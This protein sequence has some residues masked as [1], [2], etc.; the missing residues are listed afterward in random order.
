[1]RWFSILKQGRF[2]YMEFQRH[3]RLERINRDF[4]LQRAYD[5]YTIKDRVWNQ[6]IDRNTPKQNYEGHTFDGEGVNMPSIP[7][8]EHYLG[9]YLTQDDFTLHSRNFLPSKL[10]RYD[11]NHQEV[12]LDR[13][14]GEDG[15]REIM[16]RYLEEVDIMPEEE[17]K[18]VMTHRFSD[19]REINIISPIYGGSNIGNE[20]FRSKGVTGEI[21]RFLEE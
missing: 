18:E 16:R 11:R 10:E 20:N 15:Q 1:M 4:P 14:G 19:G 8:L 7:L 13:L 9:R 2:H 5:S 6:A 21:N 12:L 3:E 17:D